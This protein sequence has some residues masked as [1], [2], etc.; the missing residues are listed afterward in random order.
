MGRVAPV[1]MDAVLSPSNLMR[2]KSRMS[3]TS[4]SRSAGTSTP[5]RKDASD[6]SRSSSSAWD[7]AFAALRCP[8]PTE[9][10]TTTTVVRGGFGGGRPGTAGRPVGRGQ[11]GGNCRRDAGRGQGGPVGGRRDEGRRRGRGTPRRSRGAR[12]RVPVRSGD[13]GSAPCRNDRGK[14]RVGLAR[15]GRFVSDHVLHL[16]ASDPPFA[17]SRPRCRKIAANGRGGRQPERAARDGRQYDGRQCGGRPPAVRGCPPSAP[18]KC[19]NAPGETRRQR[20][21]ATPAEMP[22][23]PTNRRLQNASL[24][25]IMFGLSLRGRKTAPSS[26]G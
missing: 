12:K 15:R 14:R 4:T 2:P 23:M 11:G 16:S 10:C 21:E 9:A 6:V 3:S 24:F 17:P 7:T 20:P 8:D 18:A 22:T 25:A 5:A 19:R 1:N 13:G 26:S